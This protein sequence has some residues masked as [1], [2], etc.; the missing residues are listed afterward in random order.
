LPSGELLTPFQKKILKAFAEIEESKAFYLTGGTALSAFYLAHRLSE[1]FDLFTS[2]EPLISIVGRKFKSKL[3]TSG[4]QV[5][6]IRNFSSF[7]EAIAT[8]G[9][10]S[11]KIQLAFD[12]P[13]LLAQPIEKD[14]LRINSFEDIAAGK[15][16]ALFGR[17]EE[18][19]FIDVYFIVK[20]GLISLE[21][22]IEMAKTKDPGLDEYYLAIAFA[23][24]EKLPDDRSQ[25]KVNLRTPIDPSEV[26]A[27]FAEQAVRLLARHRA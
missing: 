4:I 26:K 27:F 9:D 23:Q 18:R 16:L 12:S 21:R 2:D 14:G 19:D 22:L 24:S 1:D 10:E 13:F 15:L 8:Q 25:L 7:W 17:A 11:F 6:E 20:N 3:E 5:R